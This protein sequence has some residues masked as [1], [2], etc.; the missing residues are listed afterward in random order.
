MK[1]SFAFLIL[2][3]S[4][5]FVTFSA[6]AE[7]KPQTDVAVANFDSISKWLEYAVQQANTI[8]DP[9]SR[10]AIYG[11]LSRVQALAGDVNGANASASAISKSSGRVYVNIFAAKTFYKQGNIPGYQKSIEEAKSAAFLGESIE[12]QIFMHAN[13]VSAYL[14]CNDV[15]GAK[16]YAES[17]KNNPK[18]QKGYHDVQSAY[19]AIASYLAWNGDIKSADDILNDN[20][21][22][23]GKDAALVEIA[24]TCIRK[25][26][27]DVAEQTARRLTSPEFKD[28][29][30]DKLGV[31]LAESGNIEKARTTAKII[32]DLTH[33]SFVI[34][35]IAKY[36]ITSGDIDLGKKTAGE[37]TCRDD[38]IAVYTLIAERQADAGEID[39]AV[40]T[41]EMMTKM[42]DDTPMAADESKFGTV[43]DSFK[44]GCVQTVYLRAAKTAARAGDMESYNRYIS[45]ATAGVKKINDTP[46][47]KSMV[48]KKIIEAQLEAGDIEG[49]KKTAK[50]INGEH[51]FPWAM[52]NIVKTQLKKGDIAGAVITSQQITDTMNKSFACGQI[53][54]AFVKKSKISEAK[55]ILSSLGNSPMDPAGIAALVYQTVDVAQRRLVQRYGNLGSAHVVPP[56]MR[57]RHTEAPGKRG[58]NEPRPVPTR[59]D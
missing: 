9:N 6:I 3:T 15:N 44:K 35:A 37:A 53:A 50:E 51:S 55:K 33:K 8:T 56:G 7:S 4:L 39:S 26:N 11:H 2:R 21:K 12:T 32:G 20:I 23:A 49:A 57:I 28:R 24:E 29:V 38:K 16:T 42:I 14:D 58:K 22:A 43:D 31:A 17:V 41:I 10:D 18:I 54:S 34:A 52:Y 48:F 36:Q 45:K 5:V 19:R 27:M 46:I 25:G 59:A 1:K 40:A 13:M 30:Y 47:W